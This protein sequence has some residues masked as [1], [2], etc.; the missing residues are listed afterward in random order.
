MSRSGYTDEND[1]QWSLIRWRGAVK[2]AIRGRRGQSFLREMAAALDAMP[3]KSL[4]AEELE[5]DG[6]VCALGSVGKARGI[7]MAQLDPEEYESVANAF[8]IPEALAREIMYENDN[9][10]RSAVTPE[11]RWKRMRDWV[12][13]QI[14]MEAPRS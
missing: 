4:I 11:K 3:D 5:Q 13:Q 14:K 7:D 2:S 8:G 12:Q 1:D 9:E 10:W 6:E